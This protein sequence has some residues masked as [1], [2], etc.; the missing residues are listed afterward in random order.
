M[1]FDSD[2]HRN[3]RNH[4]SELDYK[5]SE[6]EKRKASC[7][8]SIRKIQQEDFA[9]IY[10]RNYAE[11]YL[12]YIK[13]C[14]SQ[15]ISSCLYWIKREP[16]WFVEEQKESIGNPSKRDYYAHVKPTQE[17]LDAYQIVHGEPME[18]IRHVGKLSLI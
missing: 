14:S 5:I 15:E 13:R 11:V 16:S 9:K 18:I 3:L 7:I 2:I 8:V 1:D 4:I 10:K 6:L 17:E 12:A